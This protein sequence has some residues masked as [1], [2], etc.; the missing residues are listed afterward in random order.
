MRDR[1]SFRAE[2]GEFLPSD[3]W[4][5]LQSEPARIELPSH[6]TGEDLPELTSEVLG[7]AKKR[8][9]G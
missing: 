6:T 7:A 5:G 1:E 9:F 4:V 8:L 3:I 2:H